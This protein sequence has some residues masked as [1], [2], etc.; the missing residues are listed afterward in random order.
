MGIVLLVEAEPTE[1]ELRAVAPSE[2]AV[3]EL[4]DRLGLDLV[5][6]RKGWKMERPKRAAET[7]K[8]STINVKPAVGGA[9]GLADQEAR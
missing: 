3:A 4:L 9:K 6:E 1:L 5:R 2:R 7:H 8:P